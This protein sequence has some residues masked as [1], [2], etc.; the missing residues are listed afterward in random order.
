[1]GSIVLLFTSK[2]VYQSAL[3]L[4][5]PTVDGHKRYSQPTPD[6]FSLIPLPIQYFDDDTREPYKVDGP[7]SR[8]NIVVG[9]MARS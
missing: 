8:T 3:V 1:M 4:H 5:T 9:C 6:R 2:V 7:K